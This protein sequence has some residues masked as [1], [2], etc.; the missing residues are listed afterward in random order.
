MYRR[1]SVLFAGLHDQ[2][3]IILREK[4][5]SCF[6]SFYLWLKLYAIISCI[7][8][9]GRRIKIVYHICTCN[10][11]VLMLFLSNIINKKGINFVS[12]DNSYDLRKQ[13]LCRQLHTDIRSWNAKVFSLFSAFHTILLCASTV[14]FIH[15]RHN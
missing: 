1:S 5:F 3:H 14:K 11:N 8:R 12:H 9:G 4:T 10:I 15:R 13:K 2:V 7:R 6:S